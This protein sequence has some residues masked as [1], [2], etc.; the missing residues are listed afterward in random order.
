MVM[1]G[2]VVWAEDYEV[3]DLEADF[4]KADLRIINKT[5]D[6]PLDTQEKLFS[7]T[8]ENIADFGEYW[9]STDMLYAGT[10]T[11]QHLFSG[12]SDLVAAVAF[13][14]GGWGGASLRL[15][16]ARRQSEWFCLYYLPV[17]ERIADSMLFIQ[18]L[19]P[20]RNNSKLNCLRK[21]APEE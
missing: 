20:S 14:T 9:N 18:N 5:A 13:R 1:I 12:E 19:F 4:A 16:L 21:P 11:V 17:Q 7:I 10:P 8:G 15:L 3:A 2:P 6:I